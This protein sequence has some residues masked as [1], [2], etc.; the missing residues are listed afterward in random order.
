MPPGVRWGRPSSPARLR[1][2]DGA[3][4]KSVPDH[5]TIK[6]VTSSRRHKLKY[7]HANGVNKLWRNYIQRWVGIGVYCGIT[8]WSLDGR[9]IDH[10]WHEN[11]S[12]IIE[13]T[14]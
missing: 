4:N 3:L 13:L 9:T 7:L 5:V 10:L 14:K 11:P 8:L 6:E 1:P 12:W 2:I